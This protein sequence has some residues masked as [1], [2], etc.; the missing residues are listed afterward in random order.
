MFN[1]VLQLRAAEMESYGVWPEIQNSATQAGG[2]SAMC[3]N[4]IGFPFN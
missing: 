4:T 3:K 2:R 1:K